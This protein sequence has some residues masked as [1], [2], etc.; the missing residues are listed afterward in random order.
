MCESVCAKHSPSNQADND[1]D[2]TCEKNDVCATCYY[3]CQF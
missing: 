1:I 3:R 2:N